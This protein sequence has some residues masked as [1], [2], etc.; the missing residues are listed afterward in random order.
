MA[1]Q[2][3]TGDSVSAN[4]IRYRFYIPD[5]QWLFNA[6]YGEVLD[7]V[8]SI[9]WEQEG[10]TTPEQAAQAMTDIWASIMP[11]FIQIGL[12][13]PFGG[14]T[15]PSDSLLLCDG[16]SLLI[17]DYPEL[18]GVIGYTYSAGT[19]DTFNIPDLRGRAIIGAG[20]GAGLSP[21]SLGQ[22]LGEETHVLTTDE[23]P[24]HSHTT[25]PHSHTEVTAAG[26]IINGGL[27]APAA[28]AIPSVG[29]TGSSGVTVDS[30]GGG[31]AHNNIQPVTVCNYLIV[32]K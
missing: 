10:P 20:T 14:A 26:A 17:A 7:A 16:R 6:F 2:L 18:F 25:I 24:A 29:V 11:D 4:L 27:E 19:G 8:T 22:S 23:S 9:V 1:D 32:A 15:S 30:S 3:P 5:N 28:A 13:L 21:R 31:G 12:I